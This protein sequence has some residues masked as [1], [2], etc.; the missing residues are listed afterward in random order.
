MKIF[1]VFSASV[2]EPNKL[3]IA[4]TLFIP[5]LWGGLIIIKLNNVKEII[6]QMIK[7]INLT[8]FYKITCL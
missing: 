8:T 5:I 7:N 3:V 1:R 2:G 6:D 4:V